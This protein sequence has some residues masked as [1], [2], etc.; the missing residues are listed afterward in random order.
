MHF[1]DDGYSGINFAR[2]DWQ[3]LMCMIN[4]GRI[5]IIVRDMSR[6]EMD[7]LQVDMYT[8]I[9]FPSH[10][11]RFIA[12]NNGVDSI[13]G[14]INDI[15]PFINIFNELYAKN[16]SRK[17]KAVLPNDNAG[18]PLFTNPTYGYLKDPGGIKPMDLGRRNGR[19]GP[20]DIPLVHRK[21]QPIANQLLHEAANR[22]PNL[23]C[24][25]AQ[26]HAACPVRMSQS[27]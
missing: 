6:L 20:V 23:P 4:A 19:G 18:K 10:D 24:E 1:V 5:C 21:V 15:T 8:E 12:I 13:N 2:L 3:Q 14:T 27:L 7:C 22:N 25:E 9:L 16:T 11:I 17:V 26:L